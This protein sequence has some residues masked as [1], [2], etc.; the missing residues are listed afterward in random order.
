MNFS[1]ASQNPW[2][3]L[4]LLLTGVVLAVAGCATDAEN[5]S[6]KPWN[7]PEGWQHG[8]IPIYMMQPH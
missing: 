8:N 4:F 6:A 2:S 7:S 3:W 5:E 1:R